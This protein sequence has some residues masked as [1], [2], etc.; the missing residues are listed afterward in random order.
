MRVETPFAKDRND[1]NSSKD[2][3][4]KHFRHYSCLFKKKALGHIMIK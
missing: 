4:V 2:K 1:K 3:A